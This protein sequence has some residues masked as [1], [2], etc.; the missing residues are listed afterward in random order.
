MLGC[1]S[2]HKPYAPKSLCY[3]QNNC[4]NPF[5]SLFLGGPEKKGT[6]RNIFLSKI[7][8]LKIKVGGRNDLLG[9]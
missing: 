3:Y 1:N 8:F 4:K 6:V 9:T 5:F 7:Q 2:V